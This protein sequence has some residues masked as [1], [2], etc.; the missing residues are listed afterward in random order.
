VS[1]YIKGTGGDGGISLRS[2]RAMLAAI[3]FAMSK[4]P[5]KKDRSQ[6]YKTWG[7]DDMF[8]VQQLTAMNNAGAMVFLSE[9]S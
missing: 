4:L 3:D 6:A 1:T 9:E 5:N 2:R 8:F 7:Q